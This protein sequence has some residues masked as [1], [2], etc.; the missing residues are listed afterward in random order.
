MNSPTYRWACFKCG[1]SNEPGEGLCANCGFAAFASG[2]DISAVTEVKPDLTR[3]KRESVWLAAPSSILMFF[4]EGLLA[5]GLVAGS[6]FWLLSLLIQGKFAAALVLTLGVGLGTWLALIAWRKKD[7]GFLYV[8]VVVL[9]IT[10]LG[11][12]IESR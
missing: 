11:A 2:S 5:A 4:P 10:G 3:A 7:R 12:N 9:I 6:P 1:S 8:A